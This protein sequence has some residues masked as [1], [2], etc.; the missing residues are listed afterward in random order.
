MSRA[1]AVVLLLASVLCAQHRVLPYPVTE[2]AAYRAAIAAATRSESGSPGPNAWDDR[3]HYLIRA[4]LDPATAVVRGHVEA[5][6][7]NRSRAPL[8]ELWL[9]LRQNLHRGSQMRTRVVDVMDGVTIE[10][11]TVAGKPVTARP[12]DTRLRLQ[13]REPV[14]PG[15]SVTV[16]MDWSYTVPRAGGAPRNGHEDHHVFYLGYWYPQ[17]AVHDDVDGW[18]CDE[19][20]GNGEF[21]MPYGDYDVTF[22][23]PA[24]F[25]VR[26]TGVLQNEKELLTD[27]ALAA[28]ERART[29]REIQHVITP[30]DLDGGRVTRSKDGVL[31]WHFVAQ[32]V[33]DCAVSVSDRYVMDATHADVPGRNEPVA[34][35]AVY[36]PSATAWVA[37]AEAARFTIEWMSREV[38]PYPWPHMTACEGIIGGGM[39][40]PMMTL[41]GGGRNV[42]ATQGVITHELCHM[43]FPMLVGSNEK[44]F[45]W[46]DEGTTSYFSGLV[47]A[48]RQ[49]TDGSKAPPAAGYLRTARSGQESPMMTPAD[50][51]P[52]GYNFASYG[53]P[54]ALLGQLRALLR[55]G[56]HDVFMDAMRAY[57]REWA[58]RHPQPHDLFRTFERFAGR[59][60]DWYWQPW[61]FEVRTLDHAIGKVEDDGKR[62]RVIVEDCGF[63]PMPCK[64]AATFADGHV[65]TQV[66]AVDHWLAGHQSAELS[67]PT[68]AVEVTLDPDRETLDIDPDN[69]V[70][71]RAR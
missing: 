25:L 1:P 11:V 50:Y 21:Y 62:T 53:K 38:Y 9:H 32:D 61:Y 64:V 52:V 33:R 29:T 59:D 54:A 10:N 60:L 20:R 35:V 71:K 24:G 7:D 55:D 36:E 44:R 15:A 57:A 8:N 66:I 5:R 70:W 19:Y 56:D 3:V 18:V 42:R 16:A 34:I 47:S 51:Y 28:L 26:A 31:S 22:D 45:A 58:F 14:A 41:C 46:M 43:W 67:F 39:E 63:C 48:A 68:G 65:E 6:Y 49:G 69:G 13:L 37:A 30:E 12:S 2:P 4:S 27:E 40:Y 17:F 23:A